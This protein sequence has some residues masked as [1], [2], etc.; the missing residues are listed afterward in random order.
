MSKFDENMN[1]IFDLEPTKKVESQ[2][3]DL[4]IIQEEP[5]LIET[6]GVEKILQDD[7]M[8]DY[9]ASRKALQDIV[10]KGNNAIDD[11]LEIARESEHPRAFEVAATMIKNVAEVNEKLINLQKQMKD[12]TG[13]KNQGQL[14]VGKA[15][16]IGRAHV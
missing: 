5:N 13:T 12:I 9:D 7:L 6:K 1:E 3:G 8:K 15:A 11:I 10:K 16:K 2:I 4:P 14:N